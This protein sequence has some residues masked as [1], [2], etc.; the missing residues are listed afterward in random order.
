M[1]NVQ[2]DLF[3]SS[4]S[5]LTNTNVYLQDID[6]TF[7]KFMSS[8]TR[9]YFPIEKSTFQENI[10]QYYKTIRKGIEKCQAR[11]SELDTTTFVDNLK[12][13]VSREKVHEMVTMY[14]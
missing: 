11:L 3:K 1:F 8:L 4:V 10:Q 13:L 9:D 6:A 14:K 5:K 2:F 7:I 12:Y